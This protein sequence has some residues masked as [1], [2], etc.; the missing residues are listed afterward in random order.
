MCLKVWI[1]YYYYLIFIAGYLLHKV[2]LKESINNRKSGHTDT[3][4]VCLM[5]GTDIDVVR[6]ACSWCDKEYL[7]TGVGLSTWYVVGIEYLQV[8][9]CTAYTLIRHTLPVDLTIWLLNYC[10]LD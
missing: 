10:Q 9:F 6:L 5:A 8:H 1:P 7:E 2:S 4:T 3:Y